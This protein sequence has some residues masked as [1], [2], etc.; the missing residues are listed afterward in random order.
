MSVEDK[1]FTSQDSDCFRASFANSLK[2]YSA[3]SMR[4]ANPSTVCQVI[5]VGSYGETGGPEAAV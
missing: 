2:L 5:E 1:P 3:T 4:T